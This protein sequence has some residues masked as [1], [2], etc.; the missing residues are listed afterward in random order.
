[1][2]KDISLILTPAQA[3]AEDRYKPL[4]AKA[5]DVPEGDISTMDHPKSVGARETSK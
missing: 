4:V 1:V 3:Y 2:K 5:L